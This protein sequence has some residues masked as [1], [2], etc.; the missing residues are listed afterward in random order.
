MNWQE[1][2]NTD[3][4]IYVS[5]RH[6]VLHYR[7]LSEDF[8]ALLPQGPITF[9][10]FGCGEAL[11]AQRLME[12]GAKQLILCDSSERIGEML[13]N[14]F[15][16]N[17]AFAFCSPQDLRDPEK[18]PLS[19]GLDVIIAHSVAQYLPKPELEE[20]LALFFRFLKPGGML[21]LSDL[22]P[23]TLSAFQDVRSLLSFAAQ[24]GFLIQACL[25]LVRTLLSDYRQIRR[26]IGLSHYSSN[27]AQNLLE[28]AG[29]TVQNLSHNPGH[30]AERLAFRATKT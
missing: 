18:A 24:G 19:A 23:P 22:V 20:I 2:W 30:N 21:V 27:E 7:A 8:L 5:E 14:R 6:K 1:F 25:G 15:R 9:M 10:D 17:P 29:F 13:Q 4:P 12:K 28:K 16:D 3:P 26:T 11:F